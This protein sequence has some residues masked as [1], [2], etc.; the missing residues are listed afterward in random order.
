[1]LYSCHGAFT[2]RSIFSLNLTRIQT[3]AGA[4]VTNHKHELSFMYVVFYF[5]YMAL[6]AAIVLPYRCALMRT[7]AELFLRE[8]KPKNRPVCKNA[9]T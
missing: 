7:E 4:L 8:K 1:M 2:D 5:V 9:V 6:E 3:P